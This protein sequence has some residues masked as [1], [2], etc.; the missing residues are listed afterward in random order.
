M[1]VV[2]AITTA[3]AYALRKL[4]AMLAL[5]L[6]LLLGW[7]AAHWLWAGWIPPAPAPLAL[8]G[9]PIPAAALARHWFGAAAPPTRSEAPAAGNTAP[10]ARGAP[11]SLSLRGLVAGGVQPL[12]I[13]EA[14]G[15]VVQVLP[16]ERFADRYTLEE[17]TRESVVVGEGLQRHI[18]NLPAES[19]LSTPLAKP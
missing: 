18:L 9:S 12:A 19:P 5:S 2:S 1:N 15:K 11:T 8:E 3:S 10:A 14:D 17:I 4:P 13:I 7:R 16:G 6:T